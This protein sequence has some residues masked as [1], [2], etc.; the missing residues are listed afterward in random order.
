MINLLIAKIKKKKEIHS[1]LNKE[2]IDIIL[3]SKEFIEE[4]QHFFMMY[5]PS[6]IK[7]PINENTIETFCDN[8]AFN[9]FETIL[10]TVLKEKFL[11]LTQNTT[12]TTFHLLRLL[13]VVQI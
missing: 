4:S 11:I 1:D 12:K 6:L 10:K 5:L 3:Q 13:F 9:D 8:E 7:N 2:I